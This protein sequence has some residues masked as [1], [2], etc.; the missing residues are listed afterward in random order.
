MS[1]LKAKN[2]FESLGYDYLANLN[3]LENLE[4]F[5]DLEEDLGY[6]LMINW[7]K[8]TAVIIQHVYNEGFDIFPLN[9]KSDKDVGKVLTRMMNTKT[10]RSSVTEM[11]NKT[12][13]EHIQKYPPAYDINIDDNRNR[14]MKMY[15]QYKNIIK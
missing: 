1:A 5:N 2:E 7:K 15:E 10:L 8:K 11:V 3:D 13:K 6:Y 4:N 12:Q 14:L 9:K